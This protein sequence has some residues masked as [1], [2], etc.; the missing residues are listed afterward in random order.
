MILGGF[1]GLTL[2][3]GKQK[4]I[5]AEVPALEGLLYS[6][7]KSLYST[8]AQT[9]LTG[10]FGPLLGSCAGLE[11]S[12]TRVTQPSSREREVKLVPAKL[13][14]GAATGDAGRGGI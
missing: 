6:Y 13:E 4:R 10:C 12:L 11:G 9:S 3:T 5:P 7:K 8:T 1:G 2:S 14:A